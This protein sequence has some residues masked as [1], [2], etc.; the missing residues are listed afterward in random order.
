MIRLSWTVYNPL[1]NA[2]VTGRLE[3]LQSTSMD[4]SGI[5]DRVRF[6]IACG[7]LASFSSAWWRDFETRYSSLF[8]MRSVNGNTLT[9]AE[10]MIKA[11]TFMTRIKHRHPLFSFRP[12][13]TNRAHFQG[14][15][16]STLE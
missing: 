8:D 12:S 5:K 15:R 16:F 7:I 11:S 3:G 6:S 1:F 4:S 2:V 13:P 9:V 10:T 14:V